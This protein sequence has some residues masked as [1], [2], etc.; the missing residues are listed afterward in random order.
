MAAKAFSLPQPA[1]SSS[2]HSIAL[3]VTEVKGKIAT[4]TH[5]IQRPDVWSGRVVWCHWM[6]QPDAEAP[7]GRAWT[8]RGN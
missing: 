8:Q 1:W 7:G 5:P 2:V 4:P 3:T 6:Y